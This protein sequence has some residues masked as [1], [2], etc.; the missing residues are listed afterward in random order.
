MEKLDLN[1]LVSD[2]DIGAV[3][4]HS[5]GGLAAEGLDVVRRQGIGLDSL[6]F[7]WA[8]RAM[9]KR[10][11]DAPEGPPLLLPDDVEPG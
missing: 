11:G 1:A 6:I 3:I 4:A 10:L 5:T 7:R 9:P 8:A 2:T